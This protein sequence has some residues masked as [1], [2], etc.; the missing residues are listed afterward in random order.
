MSET[1]GDAANESDFDNAAPIISNDNDTRFHNDKKHNTMP[2]NKKFNY[3]DSSNTNGND[4]T[5]EAAGGHAVAKNKSWRTARNNQDNYNQNEDER[6][7][8]AKQYSSDFSG[9]CLFA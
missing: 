3:T 7:P 9:I 1:G 4:G 6:A 5:F 8:Q 2:R